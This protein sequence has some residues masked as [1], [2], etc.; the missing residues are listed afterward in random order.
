MATCMY[1]SHP[2]PDGA[3]FCPDCGKKQVKVYQQTFR[4]ENMSEEEFI[5]RINEWFASYPRVANVKGQFLLNSAVGLMVNKY[6]LDAFA[7][8]Y[9]LLDSNN[10]NQYGVVSL[11]KFGLIRTDADQLIKEWQAHNPGATILKTAG[12][13]HQRG[14]VGSLALG[15]FGASNKTQSY[16]FFKFNRKT[17]TAQLPPQK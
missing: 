17:G 16:L 10:V 6:R 11:E 4:R 7:I 12:G 3:T 1:C 15:G 9:E 8:E 5:A 2:I 13:V 14:Q